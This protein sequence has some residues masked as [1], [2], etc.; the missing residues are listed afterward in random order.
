MT[1]K[2]H[3][4]ALCLTAMVTLFFVSCKDSYQLTRQSDM[5]A[6]TRTAEFDMPD[7]TIP[8]FP[9]RTLSILDCGADPTG[10]TLSTMAIQ[11]AIDSL[12]EMG[13][14]TVILPKGVY[15]TGPITLRSH[16]RLYTDYDCVVLFSP[17]YNL[18]P[19]FE[20][21]FEGVNTHRCQSPLSA[22]QAENIAITG[23]GTFNGNGDYW[24]PLKRS[25]VTESQWKKHLQ[26]G[27]VLSDDGNVWYPNEG[28]KFGATLCVDQNVPVVDSDS[29]WAYIHAFLRPVMVHFV[30]CKNVL[31][32]GVCFENSPAWNLHPLMCENVILNHLTVR[33]PWYSQNGDG[34]DVESCR[35]VMISDC[36]FDVGDD[37]ICMKSGKDEDGRRRAIPTENVFVNHC[38]VYHGHG[39]FVV[40]SE[41]SGDVRNIQVQNCTFLGTDVG[42]RFKSTR[43]RGGVVENIYIRDIYMWAIPNEAL[44]F[45]LFYGGKGAG[46]ETEEELAARMNAEAPAAD[47]TTPAFRHIFIRDVVAKDVRSAMLFNGL[48]EMPIQDV[49]LSN[50]TMSGTRGAIIRQT[51]GLTVDNV[52]LVVAEGEPWSIASS[53]RNAS[54]K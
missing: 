43:G 39:G 21:S 54:I 32:E 52:N 3:I 48:P 33:N 50:I 14:G 31:L 4:P 19:Q 38:T 5:D 44:L 24:R 23:H 7:I 30:G 1:H 15:L 26:R 46:E 35:N 47:I 17:D 29:M 37:A 11:G 27:G 41:M 51:D 36:S 9:S 22:F 16:I 2:F 20:T 49:N 18:Y 6:L 25:K 12:A 13:G 8:S 40:G 42:L 28:A 10:Q 53:V 45:D 34:V